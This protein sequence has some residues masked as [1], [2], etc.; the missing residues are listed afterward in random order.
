MT[1]EILVIDDDRLI[2]EMLSYY[3]KSQGYAV[4]ACDGGQAGIAQCRERLPAAVLC[5]LRMPQMDGLAVLDVLHGEF[6]ELP[7]IVVSGTGDMGDAIAA[8]KLG[9]SD[10]IT[11]P[12][13][14]FAV[15]DHAVGK[16][17][18]WVRLQA[19]NRAYRAH[20]EAANA[21]LEQS[22]NQ[23]EADE[24]SG[25][26]IQFAM[27]PQRAV[28]FGA[29]ECSHHLAT[30]A[31]LSGDF[32]DYFSIDDDHF[33]F[34]MADVSGHGVSSA[35]IT[36]LLKCYVGRYLE[37]YRHYEDPTI[38]HPAALLTAL[39]QEIL[40]GEHG[41]YLTMFYGVVALPEDRMDFANGGQFPFPLLYD[42]DAVREI[43]GRSPPVG[44]FGAARYNRQSLDL[45]SSCALRLF[46]DGAL[47]LLPEAALQGKKDAL[48]QLA[49]DTTCDAQGLA[50]A[51][52]LVD[53][54]DLPDDVSVLSL[55]KFNGHA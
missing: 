43:G 11:K 50:Q 3:L 36:V 48:N 13:E 52:G 20:L 55:R 2:R 9:A 32:V 17:L 10:F 7:V 8:L 26:K 54:E 21:R 25:R 6:P 41:K 27:L 24:E 34:Y 28:R 5:D 51:L 1:T 18:E 44:L 14:D 40:V 38:L 29:Y 19:E 53:R 22:L 15:L 4:V 47:E 45:P 46:S 42:G 31:I 12:I 35:V 39:N 30:S 37:N 16:S 33:G 23:L 49:A